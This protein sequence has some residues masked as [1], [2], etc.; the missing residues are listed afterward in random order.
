MKFNIYEEERRIDWNNK[1]KY[2]A[3]NERIKDF[4]IIPNK[5]KSCKFGYT[6]QQKQINKYGIDR[7]L[8]DDDYIVA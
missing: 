7:I 1:V 2:F 8:S 4:E 6:E 5:K 3:R